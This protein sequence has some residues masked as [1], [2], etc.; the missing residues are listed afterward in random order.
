[1]LQGDLKFIILGQL[2]FVIDTE[3]DFCNNITY[4]HSL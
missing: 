1:M 4:T 3:F 2:D